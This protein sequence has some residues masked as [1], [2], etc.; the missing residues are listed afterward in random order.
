M[1]DFLYT[2]QIK[3]RLVLSNTLKTSGNYIYRYPN[4]KEIS[5]LPHITLM[6]SVCISEQ[7]ATISLYS[8][9]WLLS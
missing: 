9:N 1:S 3:K 5:I 4:I 8:I 2:F 7:I 6:C